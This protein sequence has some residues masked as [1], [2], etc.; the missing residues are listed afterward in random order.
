MTK[1]MCENYF[2]GVALRGHPSLR[3]RFPPTVEVPD[4]GVATECH[5]YKCF[6]TTLSQPSHPCSFALAIFK[7]FSTVLCEIGVPSALKT[8]AISFAL[9]PPK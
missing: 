9:K 8:S 1:G 7:S 3:L 6:H 2:V 4:D 5:P